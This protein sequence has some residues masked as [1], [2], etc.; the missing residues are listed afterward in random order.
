MKAEYS[1]KVGLEIP[2]IDFDR[3]KD[4][5]SKVWNYKII[6]RVIGRNKKKVGIFPYDSSSGVRCGI[7]SEG[8]ISL[9]GARKDPIYLY[10]PRDI[11]IILDRVEGAG[12][13]IIEPKTLLAESLGH[14]AKFEDPEGNLIYLHSLEKKSSL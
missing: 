5:Y 8:K 3:A 6:E 14:F 2:V 10:C 7:V 13:V 1:D 9:G 11:D 4:F 12:G